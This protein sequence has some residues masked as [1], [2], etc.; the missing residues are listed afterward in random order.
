MTIISWNVN[1]LRAIV[2]KDFF[3][4]INTMN[5][6]ILCLQETKAQ[7]NEVLKALSPLSN[8]NLYIN[9]ATKKGYS[10]TVILSKIKPIVITNNMGLEKHDNEGR[11]ICAEY[12]DFYLVNVYVPNSGQQLERLNYRAKWDADFLKY[13][14]DLEKVKSVIIAG[15]FNVAHQP[16][17]LKNDKANYNKTAGYTQIEI[18]GMTNMI[19]ADFVD[20]FRYLHPNRVA[21][22][23]WNYRFKARERNT[24]WRIDYFLLSKALIHKIKNS[25]ILSEYYGSDHCPILLEVNL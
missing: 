22:T 23:Y 1:G 14:K 4:N 15:D 3:E 10:G 13:I 18:D 7:D 16:I 2:K 21:Y 19:H 12:P 20:S 11:I 8:Y 6:D 24:G 17:D 25:V 5:P 9:S